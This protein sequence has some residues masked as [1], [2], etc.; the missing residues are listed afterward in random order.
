MRTL[1]ILTLLFNT[2]L[3]AWSSSVY[4]GYEKLLHI[5]EPLK[6]DT[7]LTTEP[8]CQYINFLKHNMQRF[9]YQLITHICT[10][11]GKKFQKREI[12]FCKFF[13]RKLFFKKKKDLCHSM[14]LFSDD[15]CCTLNPLERVFVGSVCIR[16][17]VLIYSILL[18][19]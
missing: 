11:C 5:M 7:C 2:M 19:I 18:K 3:E 14:V 1:T 9:K 15:I 13:R 4:N 12:F 16:L 17:K 8:A 10:A 6:H